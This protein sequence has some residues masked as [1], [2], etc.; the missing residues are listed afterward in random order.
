MAIANSDGSIILPVKVDTDG[1]DKGV[2]TIKKRAKI[3]DDAF[4][5]VERTIAS[6]LIKG[7]TKTANL[8]VRFKK[9]TEEVI[10][11]SAKVEELRAKLA[12]L[13]SGEVSSPKLTKMQSE[14][15]KTNTSIEKTKQEIF[16]LYSQLDNLQAKA[17]KAPDTGEIVFTGKEQAEFDSLN[18]KLD[19]LEAKL[20]ADKQKASEL[21]ANLRNATGAATQAEIEK[22]AADLANAE[23]KLDNLTTKAEIAGQKL[24]TS[25]EESGEATGGLKE[26]ISSVG[27]GFGKIGTK[28]SN[29]AKRVFVFSVLTSGLRGVRSAVSDVIMSDKSFRQSLER[30]KASLWTAFAPIY[31]YIIPAIRALTNGL[32][33][34]MTSIN[35]FIAVIS[36]KSYASLVANGKALYNQVKAY[37][38]IASA[39]KSATKEIKK[40]LAAFDEINILSRDDTNSTSNSDITPSFG[41]E[42]QENLSALASTV[43]GA[44]AV[45]L[46]LILMFTG[47]FLLGLGLVIAGGIII[48]EE[49]PELSKELD[50]DMKTRLEKICKI[51]GKVAFMLGIVLLFVPG[52]FM[53]GLGL[54]ALG[55][56]ALGYEEKLKDPDSDLS[57]LKNKLINIVE[58][59]GL[60]A[61]F[62]GIIMLFVPGCFMV[63]LGLLAKGA[64]AVGIAEFFSGSEITTALTQFCTEHWK[65]IAVIGIIM[66]CVGIIILFTGHWRIGLAMIFVGIAALVTGDTF[67]G[68]EIKQGLHDFCTE[69]WKALYAIGI[70][71]VCIGIAVLF[72]GHWKVGL[73]LITLGIA[74][75]AG[76]TYFGGEELKQKLTDF[77]DKYWA[78]LKYISVI[79]FCVGIVLLFTPAF[80]AGLALIALGWTGMNLQGSF[81]SDEIREQY[82]SELKSFKDDLMALS[83]ACFILGVILLFVPG[84]QGVGIA[85][86]GTGAVGAFSAG[87]LSSGTLKSSVKSQLKEVQGTVTQGVNDINKEYAKIGQIS[88]S[89]VN[90][91]GITS[92]NNTVSAY[93]TAANAV[94]YEVP[95]LAKGTVLPGGMPY[96]AVVNDNPKGQPNI[97]GPASLIKDMVNEALDERGITGS[98][99]VIKEE[100]YNLNQTELMT[101]MYKLVKGGER[102]NGTSLVKQ[103]GI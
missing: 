17:F 25:M 26:K 82:E 72:T 78:E 88:T 58:I 98:Q 81:S 23:N 101:I 2:K 60:I 80:A 1:L 44:A 83:W 55:V 66:V 75:L 37:K 90:V 97:E 7:D 47:H 89:N 45:G 33:S 14:L 93:S 28:L 16:D 63:G 99:Q 21:G 38:D 85:L 54:M 70:I 11:Q 9:T 52:C 4:K 3:L 91:Q 19:T 103:G 92:S 49:A 51:V 95:A 100:H 96:L 64:S 57:D 20:E 15:D 65:T 13:E 50:V 6:A 41:A 56:T 86:M 79:M 77:C 18:A 59:V 27:D 24:N 76:T 61:F 73:C 94:K 12:E 36:R 31:S 22:T 34:A 39:G 102:L 68:G 5:N 48:W 35:K 87:S 40:E 43:V 32:N 30:L 10:K 29:M 84:A 69:H 67:S 71:M 53:Y 74:E 8:A 46:G 42:I 62:L